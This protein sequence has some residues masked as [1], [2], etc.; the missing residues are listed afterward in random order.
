MQ[1]ESWIEEQRHEKRRIKN[2]S[3]NLGVESEK[4]RE[5]IKTW[6]KEGKKISKG[7]RLEGFVGS[8]FI[9]SDP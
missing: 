8:L 6:R 9:S 4:E 2:D 7:Y 5:L 3:V 1:N